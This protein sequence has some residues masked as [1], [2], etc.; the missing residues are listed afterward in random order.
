MG[1][2]KEHKIE[3]DI[4]M[5][6][7]PT[8]DK[9]KAFSEYNKQSSSWDKLARMCRNCYCEYKTNKKKNDEKYK[10]S[11]ISYK[12]ESNLNTCCLQPY[13]SSLQINSRVSIS[14]VIHVIESG[15]AKSSK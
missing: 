3:N 5:K 8:C 2:K 9:W 4:E 1:N 14:N 11:D 13:I 6:H 12:Q 10:Q 7:C 15:T